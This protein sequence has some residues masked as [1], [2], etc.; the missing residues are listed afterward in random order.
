MSSFKSLS[1][2]FTNRDVAQANGGDD[3]ADSGVSTAS[4][5]TSSYLPGSIAANPLFSGWFEEQ[6]VYLLR[7]SIQRTD[8]L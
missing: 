8:F 6:V 1:L 3:G 7:D 2:P 4:S 5:S